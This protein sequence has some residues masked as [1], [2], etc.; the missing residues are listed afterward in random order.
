MKPPSVV[1]ELLLLLA[2]CAAAAQA[3]LPL[4][5]A[6]QPTVS[7]ITAADLMTRLYIL[8]D[9]SMQGRRGGE[10]GNMKGSA[11]IERE[12]RRLRLTPAGDS[13][14]YFQALPL[15]RRALSARSALGA[16]GQ[17]LQLG[18]DFV[19][20]PTRA[21]IRPIDGAPVVFGGP[22]DSVA[23]T[24]EQAAGK[25]V[26][27]TATNVMAVRRGP[28]PR[29]RAALG[30]AA[31]AGVVLPQSLP[32][33]ILGQFMDL[34]VM[35]PPAGP[36]PPT[37]P[38]GV[39]LSPRAGEVLLGAP[40][41]GAQPGAAG[42]IVRGQVVYQETPAPAGNVVAIVPGSDPK[43]R[44][45][46]V[47]IGAHTDH[48]GV[49]RPVD[50]DSIRAWTVVMRPLGA[51]S[52][53]AAAPTPEQQARIRAV[54]DSLRQVN[55]DRPD[56]IFNGADDDGSG[57]VA[58]LEIAERFATADLRPQRS[59]LFVW[60]TGEELGLLG[61]RWFTDH[62]TVPR[63]SIVA[64]LNMDMIGRGDAADL[65]N[66]G[67]DLLQLA[68]SRRLSTELGDIVD[69]VNSAEPR[70]FAF[71]YQ[72]DVPK[73]PHNIFCRSD[74]ALYARYGIPVTF[75][76]TGVHRDY[77]QVTDEPEYIDYPKMAR[78]T[79]L[80]YDVAARVADLDHRPVID[81]PKPDPNA[82]CQ[83]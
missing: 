15:V 30:A 10:A 64:E 3:P 28:P 4:K 77:H 81:K 54:L 39:L 27:V 11:Y 43:L 16:D 24:A 51:E 32:P 12:V 21:R 67:P 19:P 9:D 69:A 59:I 41:A 8:A 23:I 52:P 5:H 76:F 35:L 45:Q 79:Q 13:G 48:V 44:G 65:P 83:P 40:L 6:P 29:S 82:P 38:V 20:I 42:K 1:L 70:P 37:M 14:G 49:G 36:T 60:H 31:G 18:P 33:E 26:L 56:S 75:F 73:E 53:P 34:G 7:A 57:S 72:Y 2:P 47:A 46:Y 62:P 55:P 63:D 17:A 25:F 80:V 71:D 50:H 22:L 61:S 78:V 68:G 58:M 66:G 74:H